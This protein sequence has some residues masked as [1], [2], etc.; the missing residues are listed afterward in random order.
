MI[1]K[2]AEAARYL[3]RPDPGRAGLLIHGADAMRVA[4]RREAAILSLIGP[5]GATEMRLTRMSGADLRRDPAALH[6]A[7]KATGFFPGPRVAFVEEATDTAFEAVAAALAAWRPGDAAIVVTAGELRPMSK[8]RKL[9][10]ADPRCVAIA[11]HDDPPGPAEIAGMV[12]AAGL[13]RPP[14][15]AMAEIAA[16]AR[17][18]DPGDF[19]QTLEKLALYKRGDPAPLSPDD[20]AACAPLS[21]EAE[22]EAL[23]D[24]VAE[25]REGDIAVLLRRLDAQGTQAVAV[26]IA[27]AR[28]FREL[29]AMAAGR[30]GAGRGGGYRR[31]QARARHARLWDGPRAE[32]ALALLV[33]T[34]LALRSAT[35]APTMAVLERAMIRLARMARRER[36]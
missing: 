8:L 6:D 26:C 16:L 7:V 1:L 18:L 11:I 31:E 34:D 33:E 36:A 20:I 19:R 23:V 35:R 5:E 22:V 14:A 28:H 25:G 27:L 9:F 30:P 13:G 3:A 21:V 15:P 17:A 29:L 4:L 12:E 24:A 2:G 10:E 32:A